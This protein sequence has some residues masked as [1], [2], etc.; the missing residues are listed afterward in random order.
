MSESQNRTPFTFLS[1]TPSH[2]LTMMSDRGFKSEDI[3]IMTDDATDPRAVPTRMN[4]LDA[5]HWLVTG[6]KTHDSLF[7]HCA[8]LGAYRLLG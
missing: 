7:F 5:M 8:F 6:A 1:P 4:M 2:A 3:F